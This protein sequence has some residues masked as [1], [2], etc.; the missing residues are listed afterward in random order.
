M[1][2]CYWHI[3]L[4]KSSSLLCTF[5]TPFGGHKFNRLPFGISFASDAS[6]SMIE[7]NFG[8]IKGMIAIHD[9]LIINAV[10]LSEHD[11]TLKNVSERAKNHNIKF[12]LK[13]MQLRVPEV[14]YLGNKRRIETRS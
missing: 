10:S 5:N 12:N 7:R 6:Q 11:K 13:K 1:A 2:A 3:E 8:D 4:D 14:K 9:D